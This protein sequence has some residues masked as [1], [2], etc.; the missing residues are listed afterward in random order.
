[1]PNQLVNYYRATYPTEAAGL[2]DDDITLKYGTSADDFKAQGKDIFREYPD[3]AEDYQRIKDKQTAETIGYGDYAKHM[4][5]SAWRGAAGVV[6]AIPNTAA[7]V[8][9]KLTGGVIDVEDATRS[10]VDKVANAAMPELS[11]DQNEYLS[12]S[13]VASKIPE[14]LGSVAGFMATGGAL[15]AAGRTAGLVEAAGAS[16]FGVA[17]AGAASGFDEQYTKALAKTGDKETAFRAGLLGA[18]VGFSE[19]APISR[20]I[21]RISKIAP[22]FKSSLSKMILEGTK[23]GLE[24]SLQEGFQSAAGDAIAAQILKYDPDLKEFSSVAEEAGV[25]GATGFLVSLLTHKIAHIRSNAGEYPKNGKDALGA[26][27]PED[28]IKPDGGAS[29]GVALKPGEQPASSAEDVLASY[30]IEIKGVNDLVARTLKDGP[31][32]V[33]DEVAALS[34]ESKRLY[35]R[36]LKI[37]ENAAKLDSL[38][39]Q[40]DEAQKPGLEKKAEDAKGTAPAEAAVSAPDGSVSTSPLS[41]ATADGATVASATPPALV[42]DPSQQPPTKEQLQEFAQKHGYVPEV[43]T[44]AQLAEAEAAL[45]GKNLQPKETNAVQKPAA[46][47]VG[48]RDETKVGQG[49][50]GQVQGTEASQVGGEVRPEDKAG[51]R[52]VEAPAA[53]AAPAAPETPAPSTATGTHGQIESA[54]AK[55]HAENTGEDSRTFVADQLKSIKDQVETY[56][57][58]RKVIAEATERRAKAMK[59][60]KGDTSYLTADEAK[61]LLDIEIRIATKRSKDESATSAAK[62]GLLIQKV[63]AGETKEAGLKRY[64]EMLGNLQGDALNRAMRLEGKAGEVSKEGKLTPEQLVN[65]A[66]INY[67]P[68]NNASGY[69]EVGDKTSESAL[70]EQLLNKIENDKSADTRSEKIDELGKLLATG[71]RVSSTAAATKRLVAWQAPSGKVVILSAFDQSRIPN[72]KGPNSKWRYSVGPLNK[73]G[74]NKTNVASSGMVGISNLLDAGYRPI[75]SMSL[76]TPRGRIAIELNDRKAYSEF[77]GEAARTSQQSHKAHTSTWQDT[78][79]VDTPVTETGE[80]L[81]EVVEAKD[82]IGKQVDEGTPLEQMLDADKET[83]DDPLLEAYTL[84]EQNA[85]LVTKTY[86]F[87]RDNPNADFNKVMNRFLVPFITRVEAKGETIESYAH[88]EEYIEK[89]LD[90]LLGNKTKWKQF[91]EHVAKKYGPGNS[92]QAVA[93]VP[94]GPGGV[95]QDSGN[96]GGSGGVSQEAAQGG[97]ETTE[98]SATGTGE[99]AAA[100]AASSAA[101]SAVDQEIQLAVLEAEQQLDQLQDSGLYGSEAIGKIANKL[102][103]ASTRGAEAVRLFMNSVLSVHEKLLQEHADEY[104][105][106][107]EQTDEDDGPSYRLLPDLPEAV[108]YNMRRTGKKPSP[109]ISVSGLS[110]VISLAKLQSLYPNISEALKRISN[111]D[112]SESDPMKFNGRSMFSWIAE[113]MSPNVDLTGVRLTIVDDPNMTVQVLDPETGAMVDRVVAGRFDSDSSTIVINMAVCRD[114]A[115]FHRTLLHEATHAYVDRIIYRYFNAPAT[116]TATQ[117]AAVDSLLRLVEV[118]KKS[119]LTWQQSGGGSSV[120]LREFITNALTNEGF[121]K[122]LSGISNP[123]AEQS[124]N[125]TTSVWT[126]VKEAISKIVAGMMNLAKAIL[127]TDEDVPIESTILSPT[128]KSIETLIYGYNQQASMM[129]RLVSLKMRNDSR[130]NP[131]VASTNSRQRVSYQLVEGMFRSKNDISVEDTAKNI[132]VREASIMMATINTVDDT[133]RRMLNAWKAVGGWAG[134]TDEAHMKEFLAQ[135][136]NGRLQISDESR[137][138]INKAL[139]SQLAPTVNTA[140]SLNDLNQNGEAPKSAK[141]SVQ[142][143]KG[144]QA[145]LQSALHVAETAFAKGVLTA[146]LSQSNSDLFELQK[147]YTDLSA[148]KK[149]FLKELRKSIDQKKEGGVHRLARILGVTN[150]ADVDAAIAYVQGNVDA[151]VNA[152][153]AMSKLGINYSNLRKK[154]ITP[155]DVSNAVKAAAATDP[156]LARLASNPAEMAIAINFSAKRPMVMHLLFARGSGSERLILDSIMKMATEKRP[157]A[158]DRAKADLGKLHTLGGTA[159]AI[160]DLIHEEKANNERLI[161]QVKYYQNIIDYTKAANDVLARDIRGLERVVGMESGVGQRQF[162]AVHGEKYFVPQKPTDPEEVVFVANELKNPG[163]KTLLLGKQ[164]D[165]VQINKDR[166]AMLEWL[167]ANKLSAGSA[168]YALMERQYRLMSKLYMDNAT[169]HIQRGIGGWIVKTFGDIATRAEHSGTHGGRVFSQ[170]MRAFN[171]N[172]DACLKSAEQREFYSF[173]ALMHKAMRA[174][175]MFDRN[176]NTHIY[177]RAFGYL[178]SRR[179]LIDPALTPQQQ[180]AK[181]IN[182]AVKQLVAEQPT[183]FSNASA[184]EAVRELLTQA[185]DNNNITQGVRKKLNL[186]VKEEAGSKNTRY[187][188]REAI[189]SPEHT[190]SRGVSTSIRTLVADVMDNDNAW[191]S[192]IVQGVASMNADDMATLYT[193]NRAALDAAIA[194]RFTGRVIEEF[195]LPLINKDGESNFWGPDFNGIQNKAQRANVIDA[196]NK[197]GGNVIRF[198]EFLNLMEGGSATDRAGFVGLTLATFE[199]YYRTLRAVN[200]SVESVHLDD[201]AIMARSFLDARQGDDFPHQWL[202]YRQFGHTDMVRYMRMFALQAS[203]GQEGSDATANLN[204]MINELRILK[205]DAERAEMA[206]TPAERDAILGTGQMRQARL[207]AAATLAEAARIKDE[208][209]ALVQNMNGMPQD[210]TSVMRSVG[211]LSGY[212]VQGFGTAFTDTVSLFEAPFRK[213]GFSKDAIAFM[214][215]NAKNLTLESLASLWQ[216]IGLQFKFNAEWQRH[217]KFVNESGGLDTDALAAGRGYKSLLQRYRELVA[218]EDSFRAIFQ[219]TEGM[220]MERASRVASGVS[221]RALAAL[222]MGLETGIGKAKSAETAAVTVKPWAP[223]TWGNQLMHRAVMRTWLQTVEAAIDK[224]V[225]YMMA[226]PKSASD[227]A[228]KFDAKSLQYSG[229]GLLGIS[230]DGKDFNY[231]SETLAL[232]GISLEEAARRALRG[233]QALTEEQVH[234]VASLAQTEILMNSS[235]VTRPA[236]SYN[237]LAGRIASPIIG[238]GLYRMTDLVKSVRTPKG[239]MEINAAK[240]AAIAFALGVLPA[241]IAYALLRDEYDEEIVGKKTNV[242]ALKADHT[243]P[244]ALM[245]QLSRVGTFGALGDFGNSMFNMS[246][247]RD[248]TVESRVFAFSALTSVFKTVGSLY[249]QEGAATYA[250]TWRPLLQSLGGSGYLNNFD[251]INNVLNLDNAE[252]RI[253]RRI[254]VT[255]QLRAIGREMGADVRVSRGISSMPSPMKPW[256]GE[257]VMASYANDHAAFRQAYTRAIEA[258]TKMAIDDKKPDA[259]PYADVAEAFMRAHPLRSVFN[260]VPTTAEYQKMLREL[261]DSSAEVAAAIRNFNSY[262]AQIPRKR[263]GDGI[264]PFYGTD[265]KNGKKAKTQRESTTMGSGYRSLITTF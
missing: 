227:P 190:M 236:W 130:I 16:T 147:N 258:A 197:S 50:G 169:Y 176:F 238:W 32:A 172:Y 199:K 253:V 62:V 189:G 29:G 183:A 195:V 15:G 255:N 4:A 73:K 91:N 152:L 81:S 185:V 53:P 126:S 134:K 2:S 242:L 232:N 219:R 45:S 112:S 218:D 187:V 113:A 88:M 191:N 249:Q 173:D 97:A 217:T 87:W 174:T 60:G 129:D 208:F 252:R 143:L 101:G 159:R 118:A 162:A 8:T 69:F 200:Q 141:D 35:A 179:D 247:S 77:I 240:Q 92:Q 256:I 265:R 150:K 206:A 151:H 248:F 137:K 54:V 188:F 47:E 79:M 212:T 216:A 9:R 14:G 49:V 215:N 254:N 210:Y 64:D 178:E 136:Y 67:D 114:I 204:A 46:G 17:T 42:V 107:P 33:V 225:D 102:K 65:W 170:M 43:K 234:A 167:N 61:R 117:R 94:A 56:G 168:N 153:S 160:L 40:S 146:K 209:T 30:N 145:K 80:N 161:E 110:G 78:G 140:I 26:A 39:K 164:F 131:S 83:S 48:V 211:I 41:A 220:P 182:A 27:K 263:D 70:V 57:E 157:D 99:G 202:E 261:G 194:K 120:A 58:M 180:T 135:M 122:A 158:F 12:R 259:D 171:S 230:I 1:M 104:G 66:S 233:E 10:A 11:Q 133:V 184:V 116:V 119:G 226:H 243:L 95:Q 165:P 264:T 103:E 221:H 250:T 201:G 155:V 106:P 142:I 138:A 44:A 132:A 124:S 13:F 251:A 222:R 193:S 31:E 198:A 115:D 76:L 37:A 3:F 207:T 19:V 63:A 260:K 128:I 105:E 86:E 139:T 55:F 257:M 93:N 21:D 125:T 121:Q 24:E 109:P 246:T 192:M 186:K 148:T 25:G 59:E 224:S 7:T 127:G 149:E 181:S 156:D 96:S 52:K 241:S 154:T 229:K 228:F 231:L 85:D 108:R 144:L 74:N 75:A 205:A 18:G 22:S 196:W 214:F 84:I 38:I 36:K 82:K 177:N 23:E 175:G 71:S 111:V 237:S 34:D 123:F 100:D 235:V 72:A 20:F 223:F 262:G 6:G 28:T 239:R 166:F 89:I 245:D 98:G 213:F 163:Y 68:Q 51:E 244:L 90:S 203:F 5:G